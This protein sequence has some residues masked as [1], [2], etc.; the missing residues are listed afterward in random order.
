V[1][2]HNGQVSRLLTIAAAD[3]PG[4]PRTSDLTAAPSSAQIAVAFTR[5][6]MSV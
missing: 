3:V 6:V 4:K 1:I 5:S 2:F